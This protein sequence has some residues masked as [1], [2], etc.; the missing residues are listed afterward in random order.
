[1]L[2]HEIW[3]DLDEP[4]P[5]REQERRWQEALEALERAARAW[6][7]LRAGELGQV[8]NYLLYDLI[9]AGPRAAAAK[10]GTLTPR[11]RLTPTPA[12]PEPVR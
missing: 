4:P 7:E 2:L 10:G 6:Q 11:E 8:D 9:T 1:M 5:P 3:S 12:S